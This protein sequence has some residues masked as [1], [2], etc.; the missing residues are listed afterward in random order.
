MNNCPLLVKKKSLVT[1]DPRKQTPKLAI[2]KTEK[3]PNLHY[4]TGKHQKT[5]L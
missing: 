2:V 5:E 1:E 3:N 4:K